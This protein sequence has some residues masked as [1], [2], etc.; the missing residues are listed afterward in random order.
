MFPPVPQD[1]QYLQ[2]E[3]ALGLPRLDSLRGLELA[4]GQPDTTD[5]LAYWEA[6]RLRP[7]PKEPE[8]CSVVAIEQAA[9][10]L[11]K[12]GRWAEARG[13]FGLLSELAGS[14]SQQQLTDVQVQTRADKHR[15]GTEWFQELSKRASVRFEWRGLRLQAIGR[16]R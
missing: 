13:R 4:A 9:C 3:C 16:P 12:L 11:A 5:A 8:S 7:D 14:K 2:K 6:Q 10:A 15:I 1:R